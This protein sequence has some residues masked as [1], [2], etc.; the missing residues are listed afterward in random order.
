MR[1]AILA[2][3][4]D[5]QTAGI[6][7]YTRQ[8][9]EALDALESEHTY[10][11]IRLKKQSFFKKLQEVPLAMP[12]LY[13]GGRANRLFWQLPSLLRKLNVDVVV[14]PAHFGPFCLPR[15]IRRVTVIHDL[16]P[17]LFPRW[18]RFHSQ[19]LQR[20]MLPAIMRKATIVITNS[21]ATSR[22]L[23]Q[24]FPF[25]ARKTEMLYPGADLFFKPEPDESLLALYGI[26]APYFLFTGTIEPR[27]NLIGLLDAFALLRQ[28]GNA[29]Y[30][31]VI[32]GGKGW[33]SGK[34]NRAWLKHPNKTN[35]ILTGYVPKAHLNALYA[36]ALAFVFPNYYEGFG[37]P[38]TEAMRC[39][40]PVISSDRGSLPEVGGGAVMYVNPEESAQ[41][42]AAMKNL[43][44]NETERN[45]MISLGLLQE[46]RFRWAETA[47]LFDQL[48][49]KIGKQ[50]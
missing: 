13:L 24:R 16:T 7:V 1:I 9:L 43:A 46:Q 37:L 18:H 20:L 3:P 11:I 50:A 6:H 36:S 40:C 32:A 23:L 39:G 44:E 15:S 38:L 28:S 31:L 26:T 22:D 4:L 10:L 25:L 5:N 35:I 2:D 27:K 8:L 19:W 49:T 42:A 17:L 48:M 29:N 47:R 45:K 21:Q 30:Q 14:E 41:L 12:P 34:F 33:K